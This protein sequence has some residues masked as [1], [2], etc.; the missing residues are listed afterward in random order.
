MF[1]RRKEVFYLM[2]FNTLTLNTETNVVVSGISSGFMVVCLS[3]HC[4]LD[5]RLCGENR[6]GYAL[7]L[8]KSTH[9]CTR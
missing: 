2:T 4:R 8:L 6:L 1:Y 7:I 9:G 3:G 5:Q